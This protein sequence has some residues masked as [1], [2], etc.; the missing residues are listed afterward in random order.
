MAEPAS[1][2]DESPLEGVDPAIAARIKRIA[3]LVLLALV[4]GGAYATWRYIS[5]GKATDRWEELAQIERTYGEPGTRGW[6]EA[7]SAPSD[8]EQRDRHVQRLE[9]F[10]AANETD[11]ALAA[12][13]HARIANLEMTQ[14]LGLAAGGGTA[15]VDTQ[16]DAAKK[17]LEILRDR[18]P[19]AAINWARFARGSAASVTRVALA[20]VDSFRAWNAKYG[21]KPVEPDA[22]VVAVLRTTEGD[23]RLKFFSSASPKLVAA[24]LERICSGAL[25]GT[26]LFDKRDDSD[27]GWVRGGD[28][29][30]QKPDPSDADRVTWGT[31]T[32]GD[33]LLPEEGRNRI[34]HT[35]GVVSA[36]HA[37]EEIS[38]DPAI[39]LL[40][41]KPSPALDYDYTPFARVDGELSFSTLERIAARRSR[42]Q[43]KP[44]VRADPVLH[45]LADHF[46]SP[47]FVRKAL[48]F[49]KGVL[50]A[51][52]DPSKVAD[53]EKKLDTLKPDARREQP[54]PPVAPAAPP[55]T[56]PAGGAAPTPTAPDAGMD[57]AK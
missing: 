33:P 8:L 48:V 14:V 57:A 41:T 23:L 26:A 46:A 51:C 32:P 1:K 28:S 43:D 34:L 21:V 12:H 2:R 6:I 5:V 54:A 22:D 11:A 47:V 52:I 24:F 50:K 16:L 35:K 18:Y 39:F 19:D 30:T 15:A 9:Q 55:A 20:W 29:R 49:E 4:L 45:D 10:L 7:A 44:E 53:D 36:W 56:A 31:P 17:H 40:V 27:E 3:V 38:D 13:V 25:D 42:A 37:H